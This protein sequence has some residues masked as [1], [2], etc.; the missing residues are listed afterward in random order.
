MTLEAIK[1]AIPHREPFLLIDEIVEQ[2]VDRIV[3]RKTFTGDEFWY[4]GHYPQFPITPGVILCE[5]AMQAG[6]VLLSHRVANDP[7]AVPVATRANNVQF[8]KMVLPGDSVLIETILVE[9][10]SNAFFMKAR[11]TIE[12]KVAVR[13]DFA[14]T[15]TKPEVT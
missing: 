8:K 9:Q 10:L 3:C 11:V 2:S 12:G 13:F 7:S 1:A 4:R 15:L 14:C 6:A 5:A